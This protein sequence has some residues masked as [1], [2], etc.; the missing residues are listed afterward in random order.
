MQKLFTLF[1]CFGIFCKSFSQTPKSSLF[2]AI[3]LVNDCFDAQSLQN[4]SIKIG[5]R[6]GNILT[7]RSPTD[8]SE[9]LKNHPGI[10]YVKKASKISPNLARVTS[11]LRADSV[12]KQHDLMQGYS[13]K[14]VIIGITDWGFD[15]TPYVL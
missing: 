10:V 14:D 3:A 11:D 1:F 12:Y 8:Q 7:L 15:Y 9:L 6:V 4:K 2:T 5:S 13:G